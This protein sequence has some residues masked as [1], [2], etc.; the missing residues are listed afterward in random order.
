M[1]VAGEVGGVRC[2]AQAAGGRYT[3]VRSSMLSKREPEP[4]AG[5]PELPAMAPLPVRSKDASE[6]WRDMV[7]ADGGLSCCA[8][9]E[10]IARRETSPWVTR[11]RTVALCHL[12]MSTILPLKS[13]SPLRGYPRAAWLQDADGS[14]LLARCPKLYTAASSDRM[15]RTVRWSLLPLSRRSDRRV[16]EIRPLVV[17]YSFADSSRCR[18][19]RRPSRR[20]SSPSIPS[21]PKLSWQMLLPTISSGGA[22]SKIPVPSPHSRITLI[23]RGTAL[24]E[25]SLERKPRVACLR[26]GGGDATPGRAPSTVIYYYRRSRQCLPQSPKQTLQGELIVPAGR[27]PSQAHLRRGMAASKPSQI[28]CRS[29]KERCG[30]YGLSAVT[31]FCCCRVSYR[32][33]RQSLAS[34]LARCKPVRRRSSIGVWRSG[35]RGHKDIKEVHRRMSLDLCNPRGHSLSV[36]PCRKSAATSR[37]S[38]TPHG[39]LWLRSKG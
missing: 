25:V 30:L 6:R 27:V 19:R 11:A 21:L 16:P 35:S 31:A 28:H 18:L 33:A 5:T 10:P 4:L 17:S 24:A 8:C 38:A 39:G 3:Y 12:A 14:L 13:S 32:A 22:K 20:P 23:E 29:Y 7:I 34:P 1:S 37:A 26:P 36:L 15:Q 9:P 2:G